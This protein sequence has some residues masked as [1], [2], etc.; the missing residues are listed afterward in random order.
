MTTNTDW[1]EV[2]EMESPFED[3]PF[4]EMGETNVSEQDEEAVS[5]SAPVP[6][7]DAEAQKRA[8]FEAAEAKR[9]ADWEARQAEKRAA[10]Q[11]EMERL[12]TMNDQE[13]AEAATQKIGTDTEKLTRRN[14]K[15]CVCEYIQTLC[16]EDTA[17]ARLTMTPPKNMVRCFQYISRKAWDYVQDELKAAG[18]RLGIG[19]QGYGCDVPDDLCY[20]WAE[21]YF[22]DPHAKEDDEEEEKFVPKTY[23]GGR[24]AKSKNK[25]PAKKKTPENTA[26]PAKQEPPAQTQLS[27]G[28]CAA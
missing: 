28:D 9:K 8:E 15:E 2:P 12:K 24:S 27:L 18:Q 26:D 6:A 22:R 7:A 1:Q 5:T 14:M 11:A 13:L 25:A 10:R 3:D 4:E 17:F 16:F 21:E 19:A 20:T 23:P